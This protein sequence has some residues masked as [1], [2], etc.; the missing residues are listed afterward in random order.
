MF[1]VI[2]TVLSLG[3]HLYMVLST[4]SPKHKNSS[5]LSNDSSQILT[6]SKKSNKNENLSNKFN[7]V[8][9]VAFSGGLS[10]DVE[11]NCSS[12]RLYT[13]RNFKFFHNV[14]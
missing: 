6:I 10:A 12:Y 11:G 8:S 4:F 7:T 3:Q 14:G 1:T 2:T 5:G 9:C 13:A